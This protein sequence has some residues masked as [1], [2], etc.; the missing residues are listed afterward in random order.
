MFGATWTSEFGF[1][2]IIWDFEDGV[3]KLDLSGSGL[4]FAD[5]TIGDDGFSAII[6]SSA[7]RIEVVGLA[8]QITEADFLF[9]S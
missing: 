2:D 6:T 3:E 5:L 8:G 9:A 4:T 1:Q 7:G